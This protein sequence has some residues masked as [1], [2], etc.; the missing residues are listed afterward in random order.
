MPVYT[1]KTLAG[2]EAV[3]AK[4]IVDLGYPNVE[5]RTRAVQVEAPER[6]LYEANY[7]L[8]TAISVLKPFVRV[9]APTRDL[10]NQLAAI[11]WIS[12]W[13]NSKLLLLKDMS[14]QHSLTT[15]SMRCNWRK[16]PWLTIFPVEVW[17]E[18]FCRPYH[19]DHHFV[20]R[21]NEEKIWAQPDAWELRFFNGVNG[22]RPAERRLMK[23][24]RRNHQKYGLGSIPPLIDPMC[25]SELYYWGCKN[26]KKYARSNASQTICLV[27]LARI[28]ARSLGWNRRKSQRSHYP[29]IGGAFNGA[30]QDG[31]VVEIARTNAQSAGGYHHPM[32]TR[33]PFSNCRHPGPT[34]SWLRIHR[35]DIRLQ[36][37][38]IEQFYS[39]I[40]RY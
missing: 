20:L 32:E 9:T 19:A 36:H 8:Y 35:N 5:I 27:S 38:A 11:P 23:Y 16:M 34:L 28:S 14:A 1:V 37:R 17:Q 24:W 10:Y 26:G 22:S 30:D 33:Q 7:R 21:V 4:E 31:R 40:E 18:A 13:T 12:T 25:G 6:F 2:L 3:C 39:D 15:A 29:G